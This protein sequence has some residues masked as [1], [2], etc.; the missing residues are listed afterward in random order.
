M[1]RGNHIALKEKA[2]V[3]QESWLDVIH[4]VLASVIK[5]FL[6]R[7]S[8]ASYKGKIKMFSYF[9]TKLLK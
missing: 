4:M 2:E 8:P 7:P 6:H 3:P 9:P 5:S 1:E